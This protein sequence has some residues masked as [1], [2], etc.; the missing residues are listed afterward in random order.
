MTRGHPKDHLRSMFPL[1]T[2][3][4]KLEVS[5][6]IYQQG[7]LC[8]FKASWLVATRR[9]GWRLVDRLP[10]RILQHRRRYNWDDSEDRDNGI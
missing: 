10:G 3:T 7:N 9:K 1:K 4:D 6:K 5:A 2:S 8:A